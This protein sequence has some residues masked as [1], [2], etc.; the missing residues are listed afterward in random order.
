MTRRLRSASLSIVL[1]ATTVVMAGSS[2]I[3]IDDEP[4][5]GGQSCVGLCAEPGGGLVTDKMGLIA[6]STV[7]LSCSSNPCPAAIVD[8]VVTVS[9]TTKGWVRGPYDEFFKNSITL[10][11]FPGSETAQVLSIQGKDDHVSRDDAPYT[12]NLRGVSSDPRFNNATGSIVV[13]N[14]DRTDYNYCV[15]DVECAF[16]ALGGNSDPMYIRAQNMP[17]GEYFGD[18]PT[19]NHIEGVA[20]LKHDSYVALSGTGEGDSHL[21]MARLPEQQSNL[22]CWQTN[23]PPAADNGITNFPASH[24]IDPQHFY[25]HAGGISTFGDFLAVPLEDSGSLFPLRLKNSRVVFYDVH[26]PDTPVKLPVSIARPEYEKAGAAGVHRFIDGRYLVAVQSD[27]PSEIQFYYTNGP[28]IRDNPAFTK[29]Y[30][31]STYNYPEDFPPS[32]CNDPIPIPPNGGSIQNVNLVEECG[33]LGL[34]MIVTWNTRTFPEGTNKAR[35]YLLQPSTPAGWGGP[36]LI[37]RVGTKDFPDHTFYNWSAAAGTA[38]TSDGQIAM[39]GTNEDRDDSAVIGPWLPM[40]Q[41]CQL[42]APANPSASQGTYPAS[43]RVSW[44]AVPGSSLYRVFR[45]GT[46]IGTTATTFL[47]DT[48]VPQCGQFTYTVKAESCGGQSSSASAPVVGWTSATP[49]NGVPFGPNLVA[50]LDGATVTPAN[51]TFDWD[52]VCLASSYLIEIATTS[53]FTPGTIVYSATYGPGQTFAFV[54]L[55]PETQYWWHVRGTTA[56]GVPGAWSVTRTVNTFTLALIAPVPGDTWTSG[57]TVNIRWSGTGPVRVDVSADG[58]TSW[59]TI[60]PS[61]TLQTQPYGV[62][63]DW[64]TLRGRIRVV[65]TA[66]PAATAAMTGDFRVLPAAHAA[67]LVQTIDAGAG[68]QGEF[69]SL[70][71]DLWG[72][73]SI[74]YFDRTQGD[75]KL[76]SKF[77]NGWSAL[78][79]DASSVSN[80][81]FPSIAFGSSGEPQIAY[82]DSTRATLR[83]AWRSGGVWHFEDATSIGCSPKIS[84]AL[85]T[86]DRPYI[87]FS[88]GSYI[89]M[90]IKYDTDQDGVLEWIDATPLVNSTYVGGTLPS[91]RMLG[92]LARISYVAPGTGQ[93]GF[94]TEYWNPVWPWTGW[95]RELVAGTDGAAANALVLDGLGQPSIA[96]HTPGAKN[97]RLAKKDGISWGVT[98]IDGSPGV[99]GDGC[100]I[101]LDPA[102]RPRVSYQ[103]NA[104]L[105]H[106]QWNGSAW[107]YDVP[108]PAGGAG[109]STSMDADGAGNSRIAWYDAQNQ[110]LKY[111][112][113]TPDMTPPGTPTLDGMA[114]RT[115]AAVSWAAPGDDGFGG[116]QAFAYD[117]R[118][119][120]GPI[121]EWT[122]EQATRITSSGPNFPGATDCA[123]A[124]EL[125]PCSPYWFAVRVFDDAGNVSWISPSEMVVCTC[126]PIGPEI[127]CE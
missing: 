25:K 115:T 63:S 121:D 49:P 101:A 111:A 125:H 84:M 107:V 97:L 106:A 116:G 33:S 64:A 31:Y 78:T 48:T 124:M 100:S 47:D 50:P 42:D 61:T 60:I 79:H 68:T 40:H 26:H 13:L 103:A 45:N 110:N 7:S 88:C 29:T 55:A 22:G 77:P 114:G 99:A 30:A 6:T 59:S 54:N 8:V 80:G 82:V 119:W 12:V 62:P 72:R 20:R 3:P 74:A 87:V 86:Q 32:Y 23:Y 96:F 108:D 83:Y 28:S 66:A 51:V 4:P 69:P 57:S 123:G 18:F 73:P 24:V 41:F 67:W 94:L 10:R 102:G 27:C 90:M 17:A 36:L 52:G 118:M 35:L 56:G 21:F 15:K 44:S 14:L 93:I 34:Y 75:L 38:V 109:N 105:K 9:D 43:V 70:G 126:S 85:D 58:G 5:E 112:Q 81:W 19:T 2:L 113:S 104:L 71:H 76:A 117:V 37:T 11:F 127:M 92:D 122:F 53:G 95:M 39:Y 91:I 120:Q 98:L 1:L 16:F 46:S 65:R 89:R